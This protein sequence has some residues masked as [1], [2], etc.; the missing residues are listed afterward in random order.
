MINRV[1]FC[2]NF[3]FNFN[4]RRYTMARGLGSSSAALVSGLS[5]GLA[6]AG[7]NLEMPQTKQLLLQLAADAEGHPAGADT[8][9]LFG[10]T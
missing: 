2:F 5:A 3:A 4:L 7:Q 9:P 10:S 1:H 6:L 8:R